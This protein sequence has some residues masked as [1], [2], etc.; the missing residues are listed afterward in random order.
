MLSMTL[1]GNLMVH[2]AYVVIGVIAELTISSLPEYESQVEHADN[3]LSTLS[4][5][6][7]KSSMR[8]LVVPMGKPK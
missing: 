2:I 7:V 5:I 8:G 3:L 1:F 4:I 6:G